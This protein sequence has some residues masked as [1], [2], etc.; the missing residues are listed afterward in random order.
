M[1][2]GIL[3]RALPAMMSAL[4]VLADDD[5]GDALAERLTEMMGADGV[6][7]GL[8][9]FGHRGTDPE[10]LADSAM[11]EKQPVDDAPPAAT[12]NDLKRIYLTA[13]AYW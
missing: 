10:G 6:A 13:R 4:A 11:P 9:G 8:F 5:V 7:N 1:K 12:L 3:R 2:V